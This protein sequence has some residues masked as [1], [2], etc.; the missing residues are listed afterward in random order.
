MIRGT[1]L[2]EKMELTPADLLRQGQGALTVVV[3][4]LARTTTISKTRASTS[5]LTLT[6]ASAN[7]KRLSSKLIPAV[8]GRICTSLCILIA[9]SK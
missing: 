2:Q 7:L 4:I 1:G 6:A 8:A 9:L 5:E 3:K